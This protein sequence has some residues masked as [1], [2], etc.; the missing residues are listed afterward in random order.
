MFELKE[1]C[2]G[3]GK[4]K[5]YDYNDN[6]SEQWWACQGYFKISGTFCSTCYD[7]ISHNSYGEPNRPGDYLMMLLK[8][9]S[10]T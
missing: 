3:C 1:T 4:T 7:K 9:N 6:R 8:L 2:K 10:V 5:P